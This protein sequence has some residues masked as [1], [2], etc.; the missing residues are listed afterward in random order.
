MAIVIGA[1]PDDRPAG[2][3]DAVGVMEPTAGGIGRGVG[4]AIAGPDEVGVGV[5]TDEPSGPTVAL[6]ARLGSTTG[7][8]LGVSATKPLNGSTG[9]SGP[10]VTEA[11]AAIAARPMIR[12]AR[13]TPVRR[14]R[15]GAMVGAR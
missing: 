4:V 9:R 10:S 11:S 5:A 3:I 8:A 12:T 1:A 2:L 15:D 6:G 13:R 7:D 14:D